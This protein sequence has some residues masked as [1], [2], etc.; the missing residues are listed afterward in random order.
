VT[1]WRK[2]PLSY[3]GTDT[4]AFYAMLEKV[5]FYWQL[6]IEG[7]GNGAKRVRRTL[8]ELEIPAPIVKY[9]RVGE[10]LDKARMEIRL[11]FSE[12]DNG[13]KP[14][15][16]TT[17]APSIVPTAATQSVRD[18]LILCIEARELLDASKM[19]EGDKNKS[20]ELVARM[21]A[22]ASHPCG[23]TIGL[24]PVALGC[25]SGK[26]RAGI[27]AFTATIVSI[28]KALKKD[29]LEIAG[30]VAKSWHQCYMAGSPASGGATVGCYTLKH[31][32]PKFYKAINKF[33]Q[34]GTQKFNS[35]IATSRAYRL[36]HIIS[37]SWARTVVKQRA[38]QNSPQIS[39]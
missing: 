3:G 19:R 17:M 32:M 2:I 5:A 23:K 13:V 8:N 11:V 25:K 27:T 1:G 38:G 36:R 35:S 29:V 15:D 34:H 24:H 39:S 21:A 7:E 14:E 20:A 37:K 26:D 6:K 10:S 4:S 16:S 31:K 33:L 18:F 30:S 9:L 28:A 22:I 12:R